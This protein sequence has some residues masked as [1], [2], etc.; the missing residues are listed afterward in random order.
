MIGLQRHDAMLT[1]KQVVTRFFM[2]YYPSKI[3]T[4]LNIIL[5]VGYGTIDCIIAGQVLSAV[6]GGHMSI[7]VG[8]VL[9]ALIMCLICAFGLKSFHYYERWVHAL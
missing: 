4:F 2:G 6:S 9:V 8:I 3:C 5:M 7:A 1:I